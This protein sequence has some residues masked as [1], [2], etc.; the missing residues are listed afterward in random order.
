MI[1]DAGVD[2]GWD[3]VSDGLAVWVGAG[4]GWEGVSGR[5]GTIVGV[6]VDRGCGSA[7][8]DGV[9]CGE[10]DVTAKLETILETPGQKKYKAKPSTST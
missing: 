5:V 4:D 9:G 10:V 3:A 7:A 6:E 1:G 2:K 8:W